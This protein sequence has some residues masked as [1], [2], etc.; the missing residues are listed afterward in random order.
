MLFCYTALYADVK[1]HRFRYL[2]ERKTVL[3]ILRTDDTAVTRGWLHFH[4]SGE[5][6]LDR[7][8]ACT[9][10]SS[11]RGNGLGKKFRRTPLS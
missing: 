10:A 3:F 5:V 4:V 2:L 11:K 8:G 6:G 9:A 7:C 1:D